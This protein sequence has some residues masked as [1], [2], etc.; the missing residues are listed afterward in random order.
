MADDTRHGSP[1]VLWTL[2]G[3]YALSFLDRQVISIL[4]ED[5]RRDLHLTDTQLGLVTGVAFALFYATL[6]IPI[7]RLAD[8][9]HRPRI[10]A[11][12]LALW[13]LMTAA[14]GLA[15]NFV[16]LA[17]ARVGVGVG[18]AG[19]MPPAH[20]LIADF[21]PPERR[22]GAMAVFQ[23]GVPL[24]V[25]LG[26]LVGGWVNEWLGW[27]AALYCVGLPG[28]VAAW[29]VLRVVPEPRAGRAPPG[30]HAQGIDAAFA[31]LRD[32]AYVHLA[33][34][35]TLASAGGYAVIGWTPALLIR[36][37]HLGTGH[38]GTALA[39]II[40]VGGALGSWVGGRAGDQAIKRSPQGAYRVAAAICILAAPLYVAAYLQ[41]TANATLAWLVVPFALAFAWMGPCWAMIQGRAAEQSRAMASALV[42][43]LL[44]LV[45]L[46]LGPVLVG[47][48]S[49]HFAAA[50]QPRGLQWAL[51][52]SCLTFA[53]AGL[54][55]LLAGRAAVTP[56]LPPR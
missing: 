6:G 4:A 26:F 3:V 5:V 14:C 17:L 25:L 24:G 49:D 43:L 12:C 16:Q 33:M 54:H 39:L 30:S 44:N 55:F 22:S 32:R 29:W 36:D 35:A 18:E 13:S 34:G 1:L 10:M 27:R 8:R 53:W 28:I 31:L 38:V 19:C 46:G 11:A 20:S 23:L 45:G 50:G 52:C 48:L 37:F 41:S 21:Y 40:G 9:H 7:A 56:A 15:T 51:V 2:A 42:L 47:G